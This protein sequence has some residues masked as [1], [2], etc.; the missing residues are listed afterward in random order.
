MLVKTIIVGMAALLAVAQL[1]IDT[2]VVN[3]A[4][5]AVLFGAAAS[6][7]LLVGLGGREVATEV[8][9]TRALRRLVNIG[10]SIEVDDV[11]GRIVAVHPT[12]VE[13][14]TEEGT[15]LLVPSSKVTTGTVIIRR[16]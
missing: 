3:L 15:T 4:V 7:A 13:I 16:A 2:T 14:T 1:G 8:A 6:F 11:S 5:A 10:D 12:A 9:S